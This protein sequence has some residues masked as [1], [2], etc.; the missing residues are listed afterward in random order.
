MNDKLKL[1]PDGI[2]VLGIQFQ[3]FHHPNDKSQAV[4][5]NRGI[6]KALNIS[7]S[8]LRVI[9]RSKFFKAFTGSNFPCV[10]IL[11]EVSP[12]PISVSTQ[13]DLVLLVSYLAKNKKYPVPIA[14]FDAGFALILKQSVDEA[15]R[16]DVPRND[17]LYN[18]QF[19]REQIQNR[20][21]YL[22]SYHQMEESTFNGGYGV[23]Q[24]CHFNRQIS[25]LAIPNADQRRQVSKDWRR[26]C[27][28]S[29]LV[30]LTVANE[31]TNNAIQ[32]SST[33]DVLNHNFNVVLQRSQKIYQ[34]MDASF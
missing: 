29:E 20:H 30:K 34:L 22:N 24:L 21:T 10:K 33:N 12:K 9:I 2:I 28:T 32:A 31:L 4:F 8:S 27:S 6:A 14:M 23:T 19:L 7:E 26:N 17:Y 3:A 16:I 15:L 13:S 5:S 11:T 18:G 25:S 1:I